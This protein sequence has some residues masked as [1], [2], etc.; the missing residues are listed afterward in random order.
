MKE[1][2][3]VMGID[4]KVVKDRK[5]TLSDVIDEEVEILGG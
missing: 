5:K 4:P 3:N 1:Y 2:A